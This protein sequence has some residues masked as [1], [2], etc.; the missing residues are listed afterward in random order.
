MKKLILTII[1]FF[2]C[3]SQEH[4]DGVEDV[5]FTRFNLSKN[6]YSIELET[7]SFTQPIIIMAKWLDNVEK[8]KII[9]K[10]DS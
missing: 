3:Q 5:D 8:M 10:I 9:G 6:N 4:F 1:L 2:S 7:S